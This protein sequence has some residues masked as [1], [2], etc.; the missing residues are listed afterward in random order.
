M[1]QNGF[2]NSSRLQSD[3]LLIVVCSYEALFELN[4]FCWCSRVE[5]MGVICSANNCNE[6]L[7]LVYSQLRDSMHSFLLVKT[8]PF[9]KFIF[10]AFW[11]EGEVENNFSPLVMVLPLSFVVQLL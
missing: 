6:D 11:Q 7:K 10:I 5:I 4:S 8:N 3:T 9:K 2:V 1:N